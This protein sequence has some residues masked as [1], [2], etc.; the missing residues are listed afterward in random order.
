[1][2]C[3]SCGTPAPEGARFCEV[4]G[5][6]LTPANAPGAVIGNCRCGAGPDAIDEQGFCTECGRKRLKQTRDH[7]EVSIA[8]NF[9]GVTDRG[10][11]HRQNEDDLAL[12]LERRDD[13]PV[14]VL[15][16]CD[17]VSSSQHAEMAS[18]AACSA[19]CEVLSTAVREGRRDPKEAMA[20]AVRAANKAVCLLPHVEDDPKDPP[21]TT[22]VAALVQDGVAT[23]GWVGDSRAYWIGVGA[24]RTVQACCLL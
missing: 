14:Y 16:V 15:V 4:D 20:E 18:A 23:I 9:G 8:P 21:E 11:R 10:R 24:Q 13:K 19:V 5:T 7:S 22:L 2:I 17:G 6:Q 12:V 3:P 1:M